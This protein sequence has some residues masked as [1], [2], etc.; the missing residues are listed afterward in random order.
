[1]GVSCLPGPS[2]S[3]V[4]STQGS[5]TADARE[6]PLGQEARA[7]S[8]GLRGTAGTRGRPGLQVPQEGDVKPLTASG[9]SG[10]H[11]VVCSSEGRLPFWKILI[12]LAPLGPV[13]PLP[14]GSQQPPANGSDR[15]RVCPA[16]GNFLLQP[17]LS[18]ARTGQQCPLVAVSPPLL[19]TRAQVPPQCG[20]WAAS[21]LC[22]R[23]D[24]HE[25]QRLVV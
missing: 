15:I 20:R 17:G 3:W 16:P 14:R 24:L 19:Q 8:P 21:T 25:L 2:E 1:M 5:V 10:P 6:V 18:S 13:E 23:S 7:P 12:P 9:P 11:R 22:P 4:H